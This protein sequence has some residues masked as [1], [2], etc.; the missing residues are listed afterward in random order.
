MDRLRRG[1][2]RAELA[3]AHVH[4]HLLEMADR[5]M[6]GLA[7]LLVESGVEVTG[8]A[9]GP[10]PSVDRLRRIGARVLVGDRDGRCPGGAHHLIIRP[11]VGHIHPVRLSALRRGVPLSTPAQW[12]TESMRQTFGLA[13]AGRREAGVT[14]AMIGW[15]L[16][17][18]GIDPSV[19][20]GRPAPQ[21]G[22][23]ARRGDG[24]HFVV[25]VLDEGQ[26]LAPL[27]A[28]LAVLLN[29]VGSHEADEDARVSAVRRFA[30]SVPGDGLILAHEPNTLVRD[31]LRDVASPV[32]E[33][34]LD[35]GCTWWGADLREEAGRYRFRAFYRGRFANEV[36]LRVPGHRNVVAALA[37]I[38]ACARLDV[39]SA[40]VKESLEEFTGLS[41][42]FESR[43]SY[44]GVTLV[45]DEGRDP[46]SV[47]E[48]LAIGRQA[49][50]KRR[51]W[52]VYHCDD[53]WIP[54]EDV[55]PF[56]SAFAAADRVLIMDG[57]SALAGECG[58]NLV[59]RELVAA[60][61]WACRVV[62]LDDALRTL[63]R[64]LEPGDV[65]VALGAGDVGTIA[66]AFI[67][68]LPRDHQ[69]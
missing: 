64:D 60:G 47:S 27:G 34:S 1:D 50:G 53:G 2:A 45:D 21:L 38:A 48:S 11:D 56:T 4:A 18:A 68:R 5:G 39:P 20:V 6:S 19:M 59:V 30:A 40:E 7:Q 33:L 69:G 14:A 25:E 49:F 23:W 54:E 46:S 3:P 58:S 62:D 55:G 51:L 42:D 12:L 13:V 16:T 35:R 66:D 29:V 65:L 28:R 43:G 44:R 26:E 10:Q 67:R 63:D 37:A 57:H 22:G 8:T 15:I 32:E 9:Q 61:I 36:R 31:A 24:P 41:R 17:N 52:A